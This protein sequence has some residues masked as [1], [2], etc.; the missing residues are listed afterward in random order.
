MRIY[1][2]FIGLAVMFSCDQSYKREERK[3]GSAI[4]K[5][6][7]QGHRGARGLAPENS[8]PGFWKALSLGVS[9]LE[10]DVVVTK[11][12]HLVVSHEPWFSHLICKD[13]TGALISEEASKDYNIY[14]MTYEEVARFDC[15]SLLNPNFPNQENV[16]ANKP[17]LLDVINSSE[18]FTAQKEGLPVNYTIEIKSHPPRRWN[19]SSGP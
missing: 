1:I 10:L 9:S 15:G 3:Q 4:V 8:I 13:S 18:Q 2:V 6:D 5:F 16:A 19:L 7:L 11:D 17:K 14:K 12:S